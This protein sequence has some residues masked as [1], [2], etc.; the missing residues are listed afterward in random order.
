MPA[1]I[2]RGQRRG[3]GAAGGDRRGHGGC[4]RRSSGTAHEPGAAEAERGDQDQQ[5]GDAAPRKPKQREHGRAEHAAALGDA[6]ELGQDRLLDELGVRG[7]TIGIAPV[8]C[9]VLMYNY[10]TFDLLKDSVRDEFSGKKRLIPINL[11][12]MEIGRQAA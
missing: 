2:Q 9:A 10:F 5:H 11:E 6:L 12:A 7:K 1:A 3:A 4:P 8:G